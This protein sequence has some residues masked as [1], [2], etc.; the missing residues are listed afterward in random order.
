MAAISSTSARAA[1]ARPASLVIGDALVSLATG[2]A[3]LGVALLPLLTPLVIHPLLDL[4]QAN[5]WLQL[6]AETTHQLSDR[7]VAE[8]VFGPGTFAFAGPNGA[9]F[10]TAAEAS[11]LRDARTLLYLFEAVALGSLVLVAWSVRTRHAWRAVS[12]GAVAL[13]VAV[14]V[15]G[16]VGF[17]AFEPAFELFHEIFFPGGNWSFDPYTSHLVQL[18]PYVFWE[19]VSASLGAI[20][21][22]ISLVVWW[23]ARRRANATDIG[24][25]ALRAAEPRP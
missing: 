4:G 10:Y 24:A 25:T 18:Y 22:G 11:H 21:I 19:A 13:I 9:A 8:L 6:S 5:L 17:F 3:I 15:I 1:D 16:V 12:R 2:V 14:I 7:T 23:V 20:A